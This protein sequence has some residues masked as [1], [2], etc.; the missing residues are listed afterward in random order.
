MKKFDAIII[1]FGKAGKTLG[2]MLGAQ[3]KQVLLI[4]KSDKMYGGTCI[5]VGCI[6]SKSLVRSAALSA[7]DADQSWA[8]REARYAAAIAEKR[9][10][11][12]FLRGKNYDKL[13]ANPNVTILNAAARFTGAHTVEAAGETFEAE[14]VYINTGSTS[15][16]PA[17]EGLAGNPKA[18]Y[19]DGLMELDALPHRLSIIGGGY[20]GMEFASMYANFGAKVTVFQDGARFLPREDE[21]AADAIRALLEKQG[22]RFRLGV[23]IRSIGHDGTVTDAN[24]D[25][26]ASDAVLVAT[27]RRPN[28]EGLGLENAGVAVSQR[29]GI[30]TDEHLQTN[31]PGVFA[32]G[33]VTGG[34]QF[35]YR[36]LDDYRIL[37]SALRGGHY[38]EKDRRNL[39]Y[40]VFMATPF[41]RVGLNEQEARKAGLDVRVVKLPV[42]AIPKAQVLRRT[43]GF[44]KAVIDR[45]SGRILGAM[46]LCE[47][48]PEMINIVKLAMDFN[49]DYTVLRDQ[50]FTHPTM[51]ES[52]NDLFSL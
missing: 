20:I 41:A 50:I 5:N 22:V 39:P 23:G 43:D 27:G 26:V 33:D 15:V 1:G 21:D 46:L 29:G 48:A 19:S 12:G 52:L 37:A 18:Y 35:T 2:G 31:V 32:M 51:S 36:S 13:A 42:A 44:L 47:E 38:T 3:G 30:V 8:A 24:G 28:I 34:Q 40:S 7:A 14:R 4:E 10:V 45:E 6:P 17:I 11:T 49:A 16:V 9:R 25:T